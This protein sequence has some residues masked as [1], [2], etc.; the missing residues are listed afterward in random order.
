MGIDGSGS[1]LHGQEQAEVKADMVIA[2]VI[3]EHIWKVRQWV[4]GPGS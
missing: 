4:T 3:M 1:P 2:G